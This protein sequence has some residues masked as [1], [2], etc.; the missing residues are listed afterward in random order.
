M[1]WTSPSM[2]KASTFTEFSNLSSLFAMI[3]RKRGMPKNRF[4]VPTKAGRGRST[5]SFFVLMLCTTVKKYQRVNHRDSLREFEE[6]VCPRQVSISLRKEKETGS[7]TLG[8]A[9]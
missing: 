9:S 4:R 8:K 3:G 5:R 6:R 1:A 7:T 2:E